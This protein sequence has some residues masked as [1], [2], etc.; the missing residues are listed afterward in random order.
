MITGIAAHTE[1]GPVAPLLTIRLM[2]STRKRP[3]PAA[4]SSSGVFSSRRKGAARGTGATISSQLT[5]RF[6]AFPA[7]P[8]RVGRIGRD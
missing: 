7:V 3:V 2:L 6:Y 5:A 8:G 4:I 1:A